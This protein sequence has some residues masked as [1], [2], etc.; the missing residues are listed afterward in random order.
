[1]NTGAEMITESTES[2]AP[3]RPGIKFPLSLKSLDRLNTDSIKSP[4]IVEIE[5]INASTI[6]FHIGKSNTSEQMILKITENKTEPKIPP[7]N[8]TILLL[9][10]AAIIPRLFFPN[11]IPKNHAH[12]SQRKTWIKKSPR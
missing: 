9:G 1:M 12:E 11:K 7:I 3:P 6:S 4:T 2:N 5:V 8:P 10:L